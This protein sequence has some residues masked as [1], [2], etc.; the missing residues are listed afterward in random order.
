MLFFVEFLEDI[1]SFYDISGS[2]EC[3][4][5][6]ELFDEGK[7]FCWYFSFFSD[8]F[9]DMY[10][11]FFSF[12]LDCIELAEYELGFRFLHRTL[13]DAD[14]CSVE[15]IDSL[16]TRCC[17][18]RIPE[19]SVLDLLPDASD[20]SDN[21]DSFIDSHTDAYF[22]SMVLQELLIEFLDLFLLSERCTAS[23]DGLFFFISSE[24]SPEC[25]DRISLILIDESFVV[26]DDIGYFFQVDGEEV[27]EF[28]WFHIFRDARE[29][30]DIGK[31]ARDI[32]AFSVEFH[33][34]ELV[35]DI[36]YEFF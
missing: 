35:E 16:K 17:I 11:L 14:K 21:S 25:H 10:R 34:L 29:S 27:H 36:D 24:G 26:H 13:S 18:D 9:V 5:F 32:H 12:Y 30:G 1:S 19:S 7:C 2:I 8:E 20:V 33:F 15:L 22:K 3:K 6:L 4:S 28:F 31:E 23:E